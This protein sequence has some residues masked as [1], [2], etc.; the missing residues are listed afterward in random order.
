MKHDLRFIRNYPRPSL[1]ELWYDF[2]QSGTRSDGPCKASLFTSD[3][4]E[5]G[6]LQHARRRRVR[7]LLALQLHGMPEGGGGGVAEMEV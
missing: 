1:S 7:V 2:L 4:A 3:D 6:G 5:A